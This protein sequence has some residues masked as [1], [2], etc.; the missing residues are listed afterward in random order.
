MVKSLV[1]PIAIVVI[2][3]IGVGIFYKKSG[4]IK[5]NQEETLINKV[6]IG[7][8]TVNVYYA[9]TDEERSVGLSRFD[10]LGTNDGMLFTFDQENLKPPFWMKDMKFP[11]DIIWINDN[12]I[13]QIDKDVQPAQEGIPESELTL[14]LPEEPVDYVLE[15]NAG[16]TEQNGI[17]VGDKVEISIL[18]K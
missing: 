13:I 8:K 2:F 6:F 1:L 16:H 17:N 12:K 5:L 10:S 4:D 15:V 18:R 11:I 3:I 14:Y 7:Q 9:D